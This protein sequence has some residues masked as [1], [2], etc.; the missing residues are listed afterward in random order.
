MLLQLKETPKTERILNM[1]WTTAP[2]NALL[3]WFLSVACASDTRVLV[4]DLP[5]LAPIIIGIAGRTLITIELK[6]TTQH[7]LDSIGKGSLIKFKLQSIPKSKQTQPKKTLYCNLIPCKNK[8]MPLV[9]SV[10]SQI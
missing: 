7:T 5:M 1:S 3:N 2:A 9:T 10:L 6:E 4:T 8:N